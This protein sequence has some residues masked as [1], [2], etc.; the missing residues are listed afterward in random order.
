MSHWLSKIPGWFGVRKASR[1]PSVMRLVAERALEPLYQPMV[2]LRSGVILAHEALMR[3]PRSLG[4]GGID[5]VLDAAKQERCL[6]QFELACFELAITQWM[7]HGS[8]GQLFVN[9][10]AQT[11]VQLQESDAT[12]MLLHLMRKH[13]MSPRRLGLDI[14]GYTRISQLDVL[15]EGLRPLRDAGVQIALDNF[16][17]SETSMKVWAKVLPNVLRM[18]PRWTHNIAIDP[19]Q[20]RIVRS[21]VRLTRNHNALLVAKAVE[22]EAELQMLASLGVD[23]AQGFFLGSPAPEPARSLNLRARD[24]LQ[25]AEEIRPPPLVKPVIR[26]QVVDTRYSLLS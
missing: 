2:D 23:M 25:A 6:K 26:P 8:K 12:G 21:M 7:A 4:E 1:S 9:F 11:L 16:K 20:S 10:T 3:A 13:H 17:A 15:V 14:S 19:E 18:A 5:A 22:T 24:V